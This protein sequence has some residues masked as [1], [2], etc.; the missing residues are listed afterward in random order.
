MRLNLDEF[1][2]T[3]NKPASDATLGQAVVK[4]VVMLKD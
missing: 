1:R 4:V 2:K 3:V